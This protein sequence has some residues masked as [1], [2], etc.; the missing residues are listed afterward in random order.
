MRGGGTTTYDVKVDLEVVRICSRRSV[1]L[2]VDA[3]KK[4]CFLK[5]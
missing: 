1:S 5:M 2:Q 3:K 4:W